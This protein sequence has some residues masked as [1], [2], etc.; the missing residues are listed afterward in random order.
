VEYEALAA[1]VAK[2]RALCISRPSIQP[3]RLL[4]TLEDAVFRSNRWQK[5]LQAEEHALAFADLSPARRAWLVQTSARYIWT[6]DQV[7]AARRQLYANLAP[8][9]PDPHQTV[10][11]RIA[12]AIDAYVNAFGLFDANTLLG[13]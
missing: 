5:W 10:V 13:I 2:E 11:Q 1:L 7:Q 3:S 4:E 9:L 12:L 8:I 6:D